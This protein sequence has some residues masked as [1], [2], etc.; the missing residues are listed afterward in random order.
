MRETYLSELEECNL[1][2]WRCG[3]NRLNGEL[4]VCRIGKP[5]VASAMLHPAPPQSYTV[6]LAGCNFKCLNCQN[7]K[8]AHFPDTGKSILG[9]IAP[10]KL[11][12][13]SH[14]AI[15]SPRGRSIG[16]DRI[17]FS[18]GSPTPSLPYIEK[19]VEEAG[20]IGEVKVNYDTN[21]FMT[22]DSLKRIINFC[23]SITFDIKAYHDETHKALTGAPV[24][25]VLR[26]AEYIAKN[27]RDKLWE[28]RVLV[29]P[30][31]SNGE[32]R[33]LSKF[34]SEIDPTLPLNFLAFRPN[35][36]LEKH[37]VT[38]KKIMEKTVDISE[39][40]GLENVSWSGQV[41]YHE[42]ISET[43]L[44]RCKNKGAR[45]AEDFASG[46]GCTNHP[47]N[48]GTCDRLHKCPVKNYESISV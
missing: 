14:E 19:V 31:I 40:M 32:I 4:G 35:F 25:P 47:R 41:G 15:N 37:R 46:V 30:G 5:L 44:S 6:F 16:A 27:A 36:V 28:F 9:S 39:E 23:D 26:N 12:K 10:K 21:G 1:C 48:C 20:D 18:G 17:F 11:A 2:E 7:W 45:I 8:I 13:D 22:T 42:Q 43:E 33:P 34:L 29:I 3:R 24:G 38:T